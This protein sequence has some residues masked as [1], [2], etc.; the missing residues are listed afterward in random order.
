MRSR[1]RAAWVV[2]ASRTSTGSMANG[3][4]GVLLCQNHFSH[5][6]VVPIAVASG[7]YSWSSSRWRRPATVATG[8]SL[9]SGRTERRLDASAPMRCGGTGYD[10]SLTGKSRV[11]TV[12]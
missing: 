6:S 8:V 5:T 3:G 9:P 7:Q 11:A 4:P 1:K 10:V 12:R 2:S